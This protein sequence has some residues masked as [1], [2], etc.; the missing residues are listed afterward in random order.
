MPNLGPGM[1]LRQMD[2]A[3]TVAASIASCWEASSQR[4][5]CIYGATCRLLRRSAK[6]STHDNKVAALGPGMR[7]QE[8][9][10]AAS[11][12]SRWAAPAS[13]CRPLRGPSVPQMT[14]GLSRSGGTN[15]R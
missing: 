4:I 3:V 9:G 12:T 15:Q 2:L 7:A 6:T 10:L 1:G 11:R 13:T 5:M 8:E 14:R